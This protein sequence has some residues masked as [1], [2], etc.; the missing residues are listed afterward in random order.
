MGIET[1][2]AAKES[3]TGWAL[4]HVVELQVLSQVALSSKS[5]EALGTAMDGLLGALRNPHGHGR[6]GTGSLLAVAR[7]RSRAGLQRLGHALISSLEGLV[8]RETR[9]GHLVHV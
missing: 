2:Q 8:Q 7:Q 6:V 9:E 3:S 4:K 5:L 1:L